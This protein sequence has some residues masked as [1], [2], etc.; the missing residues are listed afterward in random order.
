MLLVKCSSI[1]IEEM[2]IEVMLVMLLLE[3][4]E[5]DIDR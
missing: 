5:E 3:V 2:V 4:V 1:I